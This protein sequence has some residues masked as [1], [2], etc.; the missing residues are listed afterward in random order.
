MR[1]STTSLISRIV[2]AVAE[3]EDGLGCSR[4]RYCRHATIFSIQAC[5]QISNCLSVDKPCSL[6]L[7]TSIPCSFAISCFLFT[8]DLLADFQCSSHWATWRK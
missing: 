8:D 3:V 4:G 2:S 7:E 5:R 1:M 6:F